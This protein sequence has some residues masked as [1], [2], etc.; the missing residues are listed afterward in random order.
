MAYIWTSYADV[1]RVKASL[2]YIGVDQV[3][4]KL[5]NWP[6]VQP[7]Y[8]ALANAGYVFDFILPVYDPS[9][10][11]IN[12]FVS[13]IHNFVVMHPNS[14]S[15]VEGPNEVNIWPGLFNGG[16]ALSNQADLQR[17][18]FAAINADPLLANLP[19]YNLTMAFTDASQY[20]QL[21][22]LSSYADYANQHAYVWSWGTPKDGLAYLL[23]F[24][25]MDAPGLTNVITET[26]YSTLTADA[27]S[28]V[29]EA[30]QAKLTLDTLLDA[31]KMGV[32]KTYL[33]ELLDTNADPSGTDGGAHW[34][35]F[36]ADGTPKPAAVALH[37]LTTIL[38]D[39]HPDLTPA[40]GSL[41]YGVSNLP[42]K[43]DQLLLEKADGTFDLVL[44]SE[45]QI[46]DPNTKQEIVAPNTQVTV[47]FGHV[48]HTVLVFDPLVGTNP[49]A[50]FSN[51]S[52]LTLNLSD[53]PL[54]I[55]IPAGAPTATPTVTSF[56]PD[57]AVIGDGV[58]GVNHITLAGAAEAGATVQIYD[59]THMIGT[60]TANGSGAWSF[61]TG[62]LA[63]G[64]HAFT[65][66]AVGATGV[67]SAA[68]S[69]LNVT[70]DT[71]A[72]TV[73]TVD[74]FHDHLSGTAEAGSLLK[75]FDGSVQIGTATANGSGVWTFATGT[76]L[77]NL[78]TYSA[79]AIDA[80]GNV[81]ANS[82]DVHVMS[83][84]G[85]SAGPAPTLGS[86]APAAAAPAL[87]LSTLGSKFD[88]SSGRA[89]EAAAS[90]SAA[91]AN[92]AFVFRH[93]DGPAADASFGAAPELADLASLLAPNHDAFFQ[94]M[95][96]L[97][98]PGLGDHSAIAFVNANGHF[99]T[100]DHFMIR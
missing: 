87:D 43:G 27:Y 20:A 98:D 24:P 66:K 7:N 74:F 3:R 61:A 57:T 6:D 79:T 59:G 36:Y 71:V 76:V 34:G 51:V 9:T 62:T 77:N 80:A 82:A 95:S 65:S 92:D 84:S 22:N 28:G 21:G 58:T 69:A 94:D 75:V 4:D 26:G 64:S 23:T 68:S 2:E 83:L 41:D 88:F 81:S 99:E 40:A 78:H 32:E 47:N 56:T 15:A 90:S 11:N 93:M 42:A 10:V 67:I 1:N 17:A 48:Q 33:Y 72:P 38:N 100:A 52:Q 29:S 54:I 25:Q 97:P 60:A 86:S 12:E 44:W 49:I 16:T 85:G 89:F 37:N 70:V 96:A 39:P 91:I 14:V 5:L 13:M 45:A 30:V 63:D 31:Y 73:P 46:W 50:T 35:L 8:H 55:E 18:F 19:V 53:H